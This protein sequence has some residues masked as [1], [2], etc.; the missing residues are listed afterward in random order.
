MGRDVEKISF[1]EKKIRVYIFNEKGVKRERE[2]NKIWKKDHRREEAIMK[3][4]C[5]SGKGKM[6]SVR[7]AKRKQETV[8]TAKYKSEL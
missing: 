8:R 1:K 6:E 3:E 5:G 2:R 7:E 4:M